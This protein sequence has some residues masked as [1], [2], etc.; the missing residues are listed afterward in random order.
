MGE[1]GG[2]SSGVVLR[3]D[4]SDPFP[5]RVCNFV[6]EPAFTREEGCMLLLGRDGSRGEKSSGRR[7]VVLPNDV[8][9]GGT[10]ATFVVFE[11]YVIWIGA[12]IG[13]GGRGGECGPPS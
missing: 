6:G 8:G 10:L 9:G 5:Y 11:P 7:V 3:R 4:K 12:P 13:V 1:R 2:D